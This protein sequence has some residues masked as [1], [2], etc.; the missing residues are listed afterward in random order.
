MTMYLIAMMILFGAIFAEVFGS[1]MLKLSDGFK[2]SVPALFFLIGYAVSFVGLAYAL[3]I[4][5]LG[6]AYTIWAGMGTVVTAMVGVL[7]FKEKINKQV[8]A[9]IVLV[10]VGVILLNV[11]V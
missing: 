11:E 6:V 10:L 3:K 5:P 2:R 8:L 1:S 7:V 4:I 9:G